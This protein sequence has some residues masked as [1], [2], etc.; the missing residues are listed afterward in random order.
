MQNRMLPRYLSFVPFMSII[1]WQR[2]SSTSQYPVQKISDT[3]VKN[4]ASFC[5]SELFR[6]DMSSMLHKDRKSDRFV[7]ILS[8]VKKDI[9]AYP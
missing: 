9:F 6:R 2:D 7:I 1:V 3:M 8:M 4:P 5:S